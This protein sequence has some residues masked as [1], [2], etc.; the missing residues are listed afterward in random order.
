MGASYTFREIGGLTRTLAVLLAL[1]AALSAAAIA[2]ASMQLDLFNRG[3]FTEAEAEAADSREGLINLARLAL[4]VVTVV[5]FGRWIVRANGNVRALGADGLPTTPG[6][7]VGYF[8][9]P[10]L[11]LWRPYQAMRDVSRASRNPASWASAPYRPVLPVWWAL[12]ILVNV[13]GQIAFRLNL[14]ARTLEE[15]KAATQV[16]ILSDVLDL[17]LCLA[18]IVLVSQV[19]RDQSEH[20]PRDS[21][22]GAPLPA[23]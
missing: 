7:A 22:T 13:A 14:R 11:N 3:D 9:V 19:A 10:I 20:A 17:P 6:W 5:T 18:A 16:G 12:W 21:G 8:F 2:S 15:F 23:E 1:S 4:Y